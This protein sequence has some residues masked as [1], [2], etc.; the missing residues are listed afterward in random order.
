MVCTEHEILWKKNGQER[1]TDDVKIVLLLR[2]FGSEEYTEYLRY[3]ALKEPTDFSFKDNLEKLKLYFGK[4]FPSS[5]PDPS[6]SIRSGYRK[7]CRWTSSF[8]QISI[9][10]LN[11]I[12][13]RCLACELCRHE[14]QA[15]SLPQQED[16]C[17]C[18]Y[19]CSAVKG[20]SKRIESIFASSRVDQG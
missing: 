13:L 10:L 19:A 5:T 4:T 1:K 15:D 18:I 12:Q 11:E 3:L 6:A 20:L 8:V 14:T 17:R 2:K 16:R 7:I 9:Q